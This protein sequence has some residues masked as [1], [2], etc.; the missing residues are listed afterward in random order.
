MTST[1]T[2]PFSNVY[3]FLSS[4]VTC[5]IAARPLVVSRPARLGSS[6]TRRRTNHKASSNAITLSA[7]RTHWIVTK[8]NYHYPRHQSGYADLLTSLRPS[9]Y[10]VPSQRDMIVDIALFFS[11]LGATLF[12]SAP[13]DAATPTPPSC[14]AA[15]L[16]HIAERSQAK[17]H[18]YDEPKAHLGKKENGERKE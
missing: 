5:R 12:A 2:P 4:L 10:T 16:S 15:R 11:L 9:Q 14:A 17:G 3:R 8:A 6:K 1:P 13:V 7:N 18:M